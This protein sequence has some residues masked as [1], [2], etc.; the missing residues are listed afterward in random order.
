MK[1]QL[2][3][4]F[5]FLIS[6]NCIQAQNCNP[7]TPVFDVDLTGQPNG[8]W[9]S[10]SISRDGKC[11]GVTGPDV[12]IQFNL[13]LDTGANSISLNIYSGAVPGGSMYYQINCGPPVAV[14]EPVCLSGAGPHVIT[15]CKPG[16]NPN[17]YAITSNSTPQ[18]YGTP[19]VTQACQGLLVATGLENSSIQWTSI[20]NNPIYNS[21]LNCTTGCDSAIISPPA[22]S[23]PPF[24]DYQVCGTE[25]AGCFPY[26]FCDTVRINF[27]NDLAVTINPANPA[28]CFGGTNAT[29]TANGSG[30]LTPYSFLW[31][32]G[33]TT[34]TIFKGPG[35]YSVQILDQMNCSFAYDT[36][37]VSGF[38]SAINADAGLDSTLCLNDQS[39][40][41]NGNVII[42]DGGQWI[43]SGTF[44]PSDTSLNA[45][46]F[47]SAAQINNGYAD[48][49][50]VSTGNYN[51][52]AD[53]DYIHLIIS[54]NPLPAI[55]GLL[56][57]CIYETVQYIT[58]FVSGNNY[59]WSV[60]G[61]IV[62][63]VNQNIIDVKWTTAGSNQISVIETNSANCDSISTITIDV[64]PK[65]TPEITG[66]QMVC[67]FANE[68]YSIV[69]PVTGN[70]YQWTILNGIFTDSTG[71]SVIAG[72]RTAGMGNISVLETNTFGC[73]SAISLPVNIIGQPVPLITG[74]DTVCNYQTAT[75]SVTPDSTHIFIWTVNG[76]NI[77]SQNNNV[78]EIYWTSPGN[79]TIILNEI[80]QT[81]CD[82]T[83]SFNVVILDQPVPI[84]TGPLLTCS[85]VNTVYLVS[86]VNP[87]ETIDWNINGGIILGATNVDSVQVL[88]QNA[89]I[90]ELRINVVNLSGCDSTITILVNVLDGAAPEL[91]GPSQA[92]VNDTCVYSVPFV[93]GHTYRWHI[94]GGV[95]LARANSNSIGVYWQTNGN[96]IVLLSEITPAGCDSAISM[97]V[98]VNALPVTKLNGVP[99]ICENETTVFN[100]TSD[101]SD[102]FLWIIN[103][104]I[105]INGN[106]QSSV[107]CNWPTIG[108]HTLTLIETNPFG[109]V[110]MAAIPVE[111]VPKPAINIAGN[112]TGCQN[113][114]SAYNV[115]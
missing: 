100:T 18:L 89:G 37:T 103:G 16:N 67:N 3:T 53:T 72:W 83:T 95:V 27:F 25:T 66:S 44:S 55:T 39:F 42:A 102:T 110:S 8:T 35:T 45:R 50:L 30:G 14:G 94:I 81:L 21:Y 48:L 60:S 68:I 64:M 115:N 15:F 90:G 91:K 51:C 78:I 113:T 71:N 104:G 109:C 34:A 40:Q 46:F 86:G 75:Y 29:L 13:T 49:Q 31:S 7:L 10:P 74:L 56:Q 61:G 57:V 63:N 41:L 17:Q 92:C 105:I 6:L 84:V 111:V 2:Y 76:G 80:N 24:I 108:Q 9:L 32:T 43:G 38:A 106:V 79:G 20:P 62:L 88:W 93:Q 107:T 69:N 22:N 36:V 28:I 77:I 26:T 59:V 98:S 54:E 1:K 70:N 85:N 112:L 11:C 97:N 87:G 65:P 19:N 114:N 33:D 47:P 82:S 73:D 23:A 52:P 4:V 12:C 99:L 5:F 96:G 101:S 58:P